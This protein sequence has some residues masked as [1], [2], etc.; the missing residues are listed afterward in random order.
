[1]NIGIGYRYMYLTSEFYS[2]PNVPANN[3]FEMES[4][5]TINYGLTFNI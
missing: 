1:M 2:D 3:Y 5:V 4:S